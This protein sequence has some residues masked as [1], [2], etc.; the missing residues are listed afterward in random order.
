MRIV[1]CAALAAALASPAWAQTTTAPRP[2]DVATIDG[3]IAALYESISGPAGA[4]RQWDRFRSLMAPGARL[5]P[6]G[7]RPDS[8]SIMRVWSA[9]E[10][11]TRNDSALKAGGFFENEISRKT[12]RYGNIVQLFST[13]ES[14]RNAN[15]PQPFARGI[16]SIQLHFDGKR[17]WI[18]TIFWQGE[19]RMHP[20]PAEYLR[21]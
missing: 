14:R 6:T 10:Y 4:D 1:R 16:N 15:D 12:D 7:V 17:W 2:A 3:I 18:V 20:I 13:Y 19:N 8:T 5:I 11:I 9:E 21:R